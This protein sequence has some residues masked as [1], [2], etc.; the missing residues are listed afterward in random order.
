MFV[1]AGVVVVET[2][3]GHTRAVS[4]VP[5]ASIGVALVADVVRVRIVG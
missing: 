3:V 4:A 2:S 5:V 1:V